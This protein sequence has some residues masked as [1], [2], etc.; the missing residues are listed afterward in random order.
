MEIEIPEM[1]NLVIDMNLLSP[2]TIELLL[3]AV[4]DAIMFAEPDE[5]KALE[6]ALIALCEARSM[7]IGE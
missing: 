4:D 1:E 6:P 3:K 5:V 7:L 2:A